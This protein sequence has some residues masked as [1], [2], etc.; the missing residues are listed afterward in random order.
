VKQKGYRVFSALITSKEVHDSVSSAEP[1]DEG[2]VPNAI[3]AFIGEV[4][5][6]FISPVPV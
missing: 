3:V 1:A 6:F 4:E 2:V 5:C